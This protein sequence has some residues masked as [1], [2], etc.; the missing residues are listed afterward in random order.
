VKVDS[1]VCGVKGMVSP[2]LS[3][4]NGQQRGLLDWDEKVGE[5]T[6]LWVASEEVADT[7]WDAIEVLVPLR[8]SCLRPA[9]G[10]MVV[11]RGVEGILDSAHSGVVGGDV[12]V[13]G[14]E[15]CI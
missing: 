8:T 7:D 3:N 11:K 5:A 4:K 15:V 14:T 9:T 1:G 2:G 6:G 10:D 13:G 12:G